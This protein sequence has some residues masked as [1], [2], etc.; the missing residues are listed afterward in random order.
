MI[1]LKNLPQYFINGVVWINSS[2]ALKASR[3]NITSD[4]LVDDNLL[5]E[6]TRIFNDWHNKGILKSIPKV[7]SFRRDYIPDGGAKNSWHLVGK[8]I[9]IGFT[10]SDLTRIKDEITTN[11]KIYSNIGGIGFYNTFIHFDSGTNQ[12]IGQ[13]A[14]YFRFWNNSTYVLK[15]KP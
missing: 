15:K 14:P 13:F 3:K 12:A 10:L 8:A 7:N 9:D 1:L 4:Y 11:P 6:L 2:K 5:L